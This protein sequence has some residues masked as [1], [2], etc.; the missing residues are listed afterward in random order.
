MN[1]KTEKE[2]DSLIQVRFKILVPVRKLL[3]LFKRKR[4]ESNRLHKE[5]L[6][7]GAKG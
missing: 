7:R 4:N 3:K 5:V 6:S 1:N 2:F